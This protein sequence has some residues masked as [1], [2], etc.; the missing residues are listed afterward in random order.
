MKKR[1][2]KA[3]IRG[4]EERLTQPGKIAIV[5]TQASEAAEYRQYIEYMQA[6]GYLEKELEELEL[7]DLQ[8]VYGLKALRVGVNLNSNIFKGRLSKEDVEDAIKELSQN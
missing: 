6:K 4:R 3:E 1:I 7:E 2:D 5:Y 8:G